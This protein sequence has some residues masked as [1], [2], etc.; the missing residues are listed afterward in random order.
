[1]PAYGA[2]SRG[3]QAPF[4]WHRSTNLI[5]TMRRQQQLLPTPLGPQ[6]FYRFRMLQHTKKRGQTFLNIPHVFFN[7]E[8]G[9]STDPTHPRGHLMTRLLATFVVLVAGICTTAM[10]WRFS[11][12]LGTSVWDSYTWATFSVAL[13]VSKWLMLPFAA[14]AWKEY[15]LRSFAAFVIWLVA[16]I[17]SFTAAIGFAATNRDATISERHSQAELRKTLEVMKQ[18]QRWQ[19]SAACADATTSHSKEFCA[20]YVSVQMRLKEDMGEADPQSAIF[21]R[22]A[23]LPVETVRVILSVFLAIACEV[24]SAL[25][26]F[27]ILPTPSVPATTAAKSRSWQ[28]P[29]AWSP[30]VRNKW[31]QRVSRLATFRRSET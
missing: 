11:Y 29:R 18:S 28:K 10:N 13:D 22:I 16:T 15:K 24:I 7:S 6:R 20:R 26:F 19:S 25:G 8:K 27:A 14:L 17:Y 2:H 5:I 9:Y 23:N 12:Q 1:M 4:L 21:A 31:Q 30:P 3:L